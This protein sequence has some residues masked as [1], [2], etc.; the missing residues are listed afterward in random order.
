MTCENTACYSTHEREHGL[1]GWEGNKK[2]TCPKAGMAEATRSV[3]KI[4][5]CNHINTNVKSKLNSQL[6]S[7]SMNW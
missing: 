5:S 7:F 2:V 1:L 3:M 4:C 6:M